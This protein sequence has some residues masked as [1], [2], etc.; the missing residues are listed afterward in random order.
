M[1]R[2][3]LLSSLAALLC[4]LAP[5][6]SASPLVTIEL[7]S[8]G[9]AAEDAATIAR[10]F[11]VDVSAD[12][13][14]KTI[15]KLFSQDESLASPLDL[16]RPARIE[17]YE[18][19]DEDEPIAAV[20]IV[21]I[22]DLPALTS[23]LDETWVRDEH[24]EGLQ[25][26]IRNTEK[27]GMTIPETWYVRTSDAYLILSENLVAAQ[28]ASIDLPDAPDALPSLRFEA[29]LKKL[30]DLFRQAMIE[31]AASMREMFADMPEDMEMDTSFIDSMETQGNMV[32][33]ILGNIQAFRLHLDLQGTDL[34]LSSHLAA[35]P[36]STAAEIMNALAPVHHRLLR[37][38]PPTSWMGSIS[39]LHLTDSLIEAYLKFI[40][41]MLNMGP[42]VPGQ[43]KAIQQARKSIEL[44]RGHLDSGYATWIQGGSSLD[45]MGLIQ[46]YRLSDPDTFSPNM[47]DFLTSYIKASDEPEADEASSPELSHRIYRDLKIYALPDELFASGDPNILRAVNTARKNFPF[48]TAEMAVVGD[49]LISSLG[50]QAVM[51]DAINR[52][53]DVPEESFIHHPA[54]ARHTG[55][56]PPE[57]VELSA[58]QPAAILLAL[59]EAFPSLP[60]ELTQGLTTQ[61]GTISGTSTRTGLVLDSTLQIDLQGLGN[62]AT[63]VKNHLGD[64]LGSILGSFLGDEDTP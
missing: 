8:L 20:F 51:D 52:T 22:S 9:R 27:F 47:I 2:R 58:L 36:G 6:Y 17:V 29:S 26:Y 37:L 50:S 34:H 28:S 23:L 4:T 16:D 53:L 62:I 56:L 41:T 49:L 63:R 59:A 42:E 40:E 13:L 10:L 11:D 60:P 33:D 18:V 48:L 54:L 44:Y 1:F 61:Q 19:P 55:G 3:L 46:A 7:S 57:S 14:Q 12:D 24:V 39:G 25:S 43:E 64:A 35:N 5:G 31:Q 21:P 45:S 38:I 32:G 30:G 15:A